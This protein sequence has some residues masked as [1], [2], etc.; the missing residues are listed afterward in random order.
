MHD[1]RR[2]ENQFAL[3]LLAMAGAA[4]LL[5][6]V[7]AVNALAGDT[8]RAIPALVLAPLYAV[9][10][11][12]RSKHAEGVVDPLAAGFSLAWL[13]GV[14]VGCIAWYARAALIGS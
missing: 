7:G 9:W 11:M 12:I 10:W 3:F 6:A 1:F 14:P 4:C 13:A 5:G 8:L 2:P